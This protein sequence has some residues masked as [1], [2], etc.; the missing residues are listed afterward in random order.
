MKFIFTLLVLVT[1]FA[2][3]AQAE[4][5]LINAVKLKLD[6][7][8]DY[9][10]KGRMNIDVPFIKAPQSGVTVYFKK[11]DNFKIEKEEGVSILPKGGVSI[12]IASLLN[13]P[14]Y[15]AVAAG[16]AVIKGIATK[17]VKL[18]PLDEKSDIV[19]TTLY[20][21]PKNALVRK[22][23][24]TTKENG[25]YEVEMDYGKY[26]AWGLPDKVIFLFNTK[27]Y[28]LPKGVTF[29]YDKGTTRKAESAKDK[30]GRIEMIYET[31]VINK[32]INAAIFKK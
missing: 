8:S 26:I 23:M 5:E 10:A 18:L 29:E 21:E 13:N 28:K 12:N 24:V 16:E 4:K 19:L 14:N 30:K 6:K 11:P 17:I 2:L 3:Y 15:T 1:N 9:Q 7:V 32:G 25:S 27:E 22:A 20:I 31:Y